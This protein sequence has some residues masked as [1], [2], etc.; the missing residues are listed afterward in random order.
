M[1]LKPTKTNLEPNR[2]ILCNGILG[3]WE[4]QIYVAIMSLNSFTSSQIIFYWDY[5]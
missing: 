2:T 3:T 1:L 4:L 5:L